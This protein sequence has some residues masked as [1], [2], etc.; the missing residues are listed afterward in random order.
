MYKKH[1]FFIDLYASSIFL[2][3]MNY[4][5]LKTMWFIYLLSNFKPYCRILDLSTIM[6]TTD[7]KST[8]L[9]DALFIRLYPKVKGFALKLLQDEDDASDV[10]QDIFIKI[11]NQQE[12]WL[13]DDYNESYIYAMTRNHIYNIMRRRVLERNY[14]EQKKNKVLDSINYVPDFEEEIY[15][16]EL[17]LL[18]KLRIEEMPTQRRTIFKLS[19]FDGKTNQEIADLLNLSIRTVERHIHL[20][21]T[22]LKGISLFFIFLFI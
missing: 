19:R 10:A 8:K 2:K 1:Y 9:F 17:E 3:E 20:A 4:L 14:Q 11:W 7:N 16:K 22:D 13:T 15:S 18:Y 6:N 12:I 5:I 21:L